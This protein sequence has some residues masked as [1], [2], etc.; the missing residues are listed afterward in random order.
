MHHYSVPSS[1]T[2]KKTLLV[3]IINGT[4]QTWS[5]NIPNLFKLS[6]LPD[7]RINYLHIFCCFTCVKIFLLLHNKL[8]NHKQ[9]DQITNLERFL[10]EMWP[11]SSLSWFSALVKNEC[12]IRR[13]ITLM[14]VLM[15]VCACST[16]AYTS[17]FLM[18]DCDPCTLC[19]SSGIIPLITTRCPIA[20]QIPQMPPVSSDGGPYLLLLLQQPCQSRFQL[21]F[22]GKW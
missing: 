1:R 3:A 13:H 14:C 21:Y 17:P 22:R 10:D 11:G 20:S 9:W 4:N 15:C 18:Q 8:R 19:M 6:L 16:Q 7:F 5:W 2:A 12:R